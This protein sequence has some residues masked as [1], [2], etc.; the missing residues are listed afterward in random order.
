[1][2]NLMD[3]L[4][5]SL[6]QVIKLWEDITCFYDSILFSYDQFCPKYTH[7]KAMVDVLLGPHICDDFPSLSVGSVSLRH[8]LEDV[9]LSRQILLNVCDQGLMF[10]QLP[11]E[12][13]L[14]REEKLAFD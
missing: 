11:L 10:L 5:I 7:S 14:K 4:L 8:G 1:M 13:L 6:C 3:L 12:E 9:V 2:G